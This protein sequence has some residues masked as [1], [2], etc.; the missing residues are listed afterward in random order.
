MFITGCDV[1]R[2]WMLVQPADRLVE[3]YLRQC[4]GIDRGDE[5]I[6]VSQVLL[7]IFGAGR[8]THVVVERLMVRLEVDRA[9]LAVVDHG[10]RLGRWLAT[11]GECR[12]E[13]AAVPDPAHAL[14]AQRV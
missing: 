2:T 4:A 9:V 1:R 8:K 13:A 12:L 6:V 7:A 11:V 3:R 14:R 10:A 5:I